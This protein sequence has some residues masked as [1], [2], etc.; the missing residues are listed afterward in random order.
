MRIGFIASFI[1]LTATLTFGG[2]KAVVTSMKTVKCG[3]PLAK[4]TVFTV[5]AGPDM[6]S[7][8]LSCMEFTLRTSKVQYRLRPTHQMLLPV[9]STVRVT[10]D[11]KYV[12]VRVDDGKEM[13]CAVMS[14]DMLNADGE[15]IEPREDVPTMTQMR[16]RGM[17]AR[18]APV[19][20]PRTRKRTCLNSDAEIVP[21]GD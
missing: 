14:M 13:R 4:T 18:P 8:G 7:A 11:K 5:L 2:D 15:P 6:E 19:M 10:V 3:A 17:P 20:V 1:V 16:T 9:G 12:M 21:C